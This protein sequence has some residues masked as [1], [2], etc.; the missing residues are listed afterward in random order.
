[1]RNYSGTLFTKD[2]E[3]DQEFNI[4]FVA[5][6][7]NILFK[8]FAIC[9]HPLLGFLL[10]SFSPSVCQLLHNQRIFKIHVLT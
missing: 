10:F 1:M 7:W 2:E 5:H 9:H 3:L 4:D 8:S 6:K